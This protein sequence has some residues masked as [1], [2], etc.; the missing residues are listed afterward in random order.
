[1]NSTVR[2]EG[3]SG[4]LSFEAMVRDQVKCLY[5]GVEL[6]LISVGIQ[7]LLRVGVGAEMQVRLG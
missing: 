7:S 1:M 6:R 4:W 3:A 5:V 2:I